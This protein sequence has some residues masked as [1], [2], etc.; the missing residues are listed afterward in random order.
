MK[1][2][3]YTKTKKLLSFYSDAI[4]EYHKRLS[5]FAKVKVIKLSSRELDKKLIG[6]YKIKVSSTGTNLSSGELANRFQDLALSGHSEV[7][8][9]ITNHSFNYDEE[10]ALS[11]FNFSDQLSLTVLYE[12]IYRAFTINNNLPYHK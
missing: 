6:T 3:I 7:S 9:V 8:F 2:N 10:L 1:I 12:Q 4:D 5:R 11:Q